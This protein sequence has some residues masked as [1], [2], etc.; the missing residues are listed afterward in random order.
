MSANKLELRAGKDAFVKQESPNSNHANSTRLPVRNTDGNRGYRSF[1]YFP[2][3][4]LPKNVQITR[5]TL[6]LVMNG[7]TTGSRTISLKR[8]TE[9][10][11]AS[12]LT[13]KDQPAIAAGGSDLTKG[14]NGQYDP[15]DF[16]VTSA[17]QI[18]VNGGDFYGWRIESNENT[19]REFNSSTANGWKPLL[20]I[21]WNEAPEKPRDL[22]PSGGGFVATASPTL[23][24]RFFDNR[25]TTTMGGFQ[26]QISTNAAM[27]GIVH[28]SGWVT[29]NNPVYDLAGKFTVSTSEP[30]YWRVRVKDDANN[31]SAWSDVTS[32]RY[33]AKGTLV[34]VS[35]TGSIITDTTPTIVWSLTGKT[36]A[37]WQVLVRHATSGKELYNSGRFTSG[38]NSHQIKAKTDSGDDVIANKTTPYEIVVRV[39]DDVDRTAVVGQDVLYEVTRVVTYKAATTGGANGGEPATV[40]PIS[41]L[42]A[43]DLANQGEPGIRLN[44][45]RSEAP[46]RFDIW[47]GNVKIDSVAPGDVQGGS[48][49]AYEYHDYSAKAGASY[50]YKV[51]AS[52]NGSAAE[53]STPV[54]IT[55]SADKFVG[56]WLIDPRRNIKIQIMDVD[57][58][59]WEMG[60]ESQTF[61]PIGS[62]RARL[63]T[64]ALRGYEGSISGL[65]VNTGGRSVR[66][67]EADMY[68]LKSTPG[69]TYALVL[70]DMSIPVVIANVTVAPT[71]HKEVVKRV[72]FNFWQQGQ[73]PF[74]ANL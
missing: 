29:S 3:N 55:K 25:G 32:F 60:E 45:T 51:G 71:P 36:Q 66:E 65:L 39:W 23:A 52:V 15:W 44:W 7:A 74:E 63:L 9:P 38:A 19:I 61:T 56:I 12:K 1:I 10:W 68:T 13:W 27:T 5:A 46:D 72:S 43:T 59:S 57:E 47:R 34:L 62:S 48:P 40:T 54:S 21:E 58:G 49:G 31:Q 70:S 37:A 18:A 14:G 73:L 22:Y 6:R 4:Q 28:D 53:N 30:V 50:D 64:Q 20:T 2:I 24:F 16:D 42:T 35:P 69:Q 17:V 8:V 33:D 41:G 26:V 11:V 67:Q